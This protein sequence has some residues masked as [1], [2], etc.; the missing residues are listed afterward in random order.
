MDNYDIRVSNDFM[1][2]ELNKQYE[3]LVVFR[4]IAKNIFS[5]S[6]II[7]TIFGISQVFNN[8]INPDFLS[9]YISLMILEIIIYIVM[10]VFSIS[11]IFPKKV[12]GPIIPD[13]NNLKHAFLEKND[14]DIEKQKLTQYLTAIKNNMTIINKKHKNLCISLISFSA[15]TINALV[16]VLIFAVFL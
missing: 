1:E 5:L 3:T 13:W 6:S 8:A 12:F 11:V 14:R 16:I 7:F 2:K 9:L 10:I 4:D 15:L